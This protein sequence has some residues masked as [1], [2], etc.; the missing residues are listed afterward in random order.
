M[1]SC[2]V[3]QVESVPASPSFSFQLREAGYSSVGA[4]TAIQTMTLCRIPVTNLAAL[5]I[6]SVVHMCAI[7]VT[8]GVNISR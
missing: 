2:L 5:V 7:V 4:S 1:P 8:H 3:L 6:L